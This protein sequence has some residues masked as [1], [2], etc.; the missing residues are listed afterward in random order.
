VGEISSLQGTSRRTKVVVATT[1]LLGF[2]SFWRAA[3]I[4]LNDLASSAYYAGGIAEQAAGKSAPWFILGVMLFSYAVRAVYV[5]SCAMFTRGG[6]YRV[7]KEAMGGTLAK[8]SVSALM[9]DYILTGPISGVTAGQYIVGLAADTF[10]Y[11]GH[12]WHPVQAT[13]DHLSAVICVL[14]TIYFW[15]RNIRGI[16]ESSEDALRVMKITTAMVIVLLVWCTFTLYMHGPKQ[17]PPA[18]T[19]GNLAFDAPS[20]GWL[21][22]IMPGAFKTLPGEPAVGISPAPR[23][24]PLFGLASVGWTLMG[25]LGLM[26]AF[27]HAV[28]AMS[29]EE[30]LA[31]VNR[32]LEHPKHKNLMRAG[33]VIFVYSLLF[34]SL[35][36]IFAG[37][38]IPDIERPQYFNNLISGLAMNLSGPLYLRLLFQGF[39]V[40]VGFLILSGAINT[41]IVGSN[42]VLN[43]LSEDG[44]LTDWFRAPQKKYGTTHRMINLIV[45]LQLITIIG[46]RGNVI[47]LGNA[48]AFG[49][50]WSFAFKALAVLVLRYKDKSPREWKVPL[51]ITMAGIEFP[52]G[53]AAISAFLFLIAVIN[54]FTKQDATIVG[55]AFTAVFFVIFAVSERINLRRRMGHE[56]VDH[57]QLAYEESVSEAGSGVRPGSIL[58]GVRNGDTLDHLR[59]V[60]EQTN[61]AERDIVAVTVRVAQSGEYVEEDSRLFGD[62]EQILFSKVVALAEKAGKPVSLLVTPAVD[63][64]EGLMM[65]AQRLQ[66]VMVVIGS[67]RSG[68]SGEQARLAG[69]A[70]EK[71]EE[72]RPRL[73]LEVVAKGG[74][75]ERTR[76]GPHAPELNA[77]DLEV[78]HRLWLDLTARPDL[79][80]LR[81]Y[82]VLSVALDRLAKDLGRTPDSGEIL[83]TF[84]CL[85]N[86]NE[87]TD[88]EEG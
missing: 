60:L 46:S 52:I 51:N 1:V 65:T 43:R 71:L 18:P 26:I 33:L 58:V 6:V 39:V 77:G 85:D 10:T 72:P 50:V 19:P 75:V 30:S 76:M 2:I 44:V 63:D 15:R 20:V 67:S 84:R 74:V 27:G 62:A 82:Q 56:S 25:M 21:P 8:F 54:M 35:V 16:H 22:K 70:W 48:Y 11:F 17:I 88:I 83:E 68:T 37:L 80:H 59:Y 41:A 73:Y 81:H 13:I 55:G 57:F 5:E 9:F 45:I 79:R 36:S 66:S 49:V 40:V 69:L 78:L 64:K 12:P 53:L 61:T 23:E 4:V 87:N 32:E 3:A 7:V 47:T 14:V 29:G 31:Q 24:G 38:M 34:T 28:L 42:G 86:E